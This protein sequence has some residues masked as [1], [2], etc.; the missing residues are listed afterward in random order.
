MLLARFELA[1]NATARAHSPIMDGINSVYNGGQSADQCD[2]RG[3]GAIADC[4]TGDRLAHGL[5][6]E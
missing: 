1:T 3:D 2:E 5:R 6:H 4:T